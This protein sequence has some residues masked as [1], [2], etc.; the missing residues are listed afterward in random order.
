MRFE[1]TNVEFNRRARGFTL[2]ELLVVIGII[3]LLIGIILPSLSA[4]RKQA[5]GLKCGANLHDVATAMTSYLADW[6]GTFP[7]AYVYPSDT[8]GNYDFL[9]QTNVVAYVGRSDMNSDGKVNGADVQKFV[10]CL[11]GGAC[12]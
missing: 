2:I 7:P 3:A 1:M 4:A 12:P 10:C 5:Q 9:G 8:E 11:L 6:N